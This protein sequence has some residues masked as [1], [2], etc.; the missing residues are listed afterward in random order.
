MLAQFVFWKTFCSA[1]VW[2]RESVQP[3]VVCPC[4]CGTG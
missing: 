1:G 2:T 4:P 3:V